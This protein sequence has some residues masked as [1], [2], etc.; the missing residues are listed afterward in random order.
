MNQSPH[1]IRPS[2][3]GCDAA[4]PQPHHRHRTPWARVPATVLLTCLFGLLPNH[5]IG[6]TQQQGE[7]PSAQIVSLSVQESITLIS[8]QPVKQVLV[9]NPG[10]LDVDAISPVKLVLSGKQYGR[11]T[12][13][14]ETENGERLVYVVSVGLDLSALQA[15]IENI[16]PYSRVKATSIMDT[17]I[18]SGSVPDARTS[19]QI[20]DIAGIYSSKMKNHMQVAGVQQVQL[21]VVIAE[22]SRT[23]TRALGINLQAGGGSAFG[24]SMVGGIQPLSMGWIDQSAIASSMPFSVTG[25]DQVVSP[26]ITLFGGITKANLEGFL[27]AMQDNSL[28]HVL[29]EPTLI[30]LSGREAS[31]LAGGEYPIPVVQEANSVT[32]E[33][34]EFGVRLSFTPTVLA[35]QLIRMEVAPEVSEPDFTNVVTIGGFSVPGRSIRNAKTTIELASG[36]T[37]AIA[38]LLSQNTRA[39]VSRVPGLG[40]LPVLGAL[41]RSVRYVKSETELL[42][43]VTPELI[44]PLNPDQL[45]AI[46]GSDLRNPNNFRLFGLGQIEHSTKAPV[47]RLSRGS[48]LLREPPRFKGAWGPTDQEEGF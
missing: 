33:F 2:G 27:I 30:T 24:G 28:V 9:A 8:P 40:N 20:M 31:F 46:P 13:T 21:H 29:A 32:V 41:F 18:L 22:V 17:I 3:R 25:G 5:L 35:G 42:I 15:T 36:Q 14:L 11:T 34:R 43:I 19:E 6:Q 16:S 23:A 4:V 48:E 10:I 39:S 12:L 26:S 47:E 37:F 45:A 7:K 44:E 38:G 1:S